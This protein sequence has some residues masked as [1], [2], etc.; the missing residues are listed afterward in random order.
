[1]IEVQD[2]PESDPEYEDDDDEEEEEEEEEDDEQD[3]ID[4]VQE[5]DIAGAAKTDD[6]FD[7]EA[8]QA[9][10]TARLEAL[11]LHKALGNDDPSESGTAFDPLN[12]DYSIPS[13]A[14]LSD[15]ESNDSDSS[16]DLSDG[17]PASDFT[18]YSRANR[19]RGGNARGRG[20]SVFGG[21]SSAGTSTRSG[22]SGGSGAK[23]KSGGR[24]DDLRMAV[25]KR[26]EKELGGK[27]GSGPGGSSKTK[28]TAGKAKGHKWKANPRYVVG[29]TNDG[30]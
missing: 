11:R 2:M 1:M 16:T 25:A 15:D 17:P 4:E 12:P 21:A 30:W 8:F 29:S 7:E 6:P 3:D 23:S 19:G 13:H 28:A 14:E 27:G 24:K 9:Q 20:G 18:T 26:I 5:S 22:M 10:M